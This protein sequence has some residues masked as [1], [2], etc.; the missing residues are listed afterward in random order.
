ML[1][2]AYQKEKDYYQQVSK[3]TKK[4]KVMQ[5]VLI[6]NFDKEVFALAIKKI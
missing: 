5:R 2:I 4:K 3:K 6:K 1:D